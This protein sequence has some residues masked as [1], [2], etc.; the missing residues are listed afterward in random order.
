MGGRVRCHASSAV[1][2]AVSCAGGGA[3][4]WGGAEEVCGAAVSHLRGDDSGPAASGGGEGDAV[5]GAV[6]FGRLLAAGGTMRSLG[7]IMRKLLTRSRGGVGKGM[8]MKAVKGPGV[9][10]FNQA[11]PKRKP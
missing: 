1:A 4:A 11:Q 10:A 7:S 2:W 5:A 8:T 6:L 9:R 3:A